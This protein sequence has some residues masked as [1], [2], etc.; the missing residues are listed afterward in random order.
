MIVFVMKWIKTRHAVM[1][2]LSNNTIQSIF[3]DGS[4]LI[5]NSITK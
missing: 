5:F 4:E 3:N 1:F 2:R